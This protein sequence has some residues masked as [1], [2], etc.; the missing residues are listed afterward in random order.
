VL[1]GVGAEVGFEASQHD[2]HRAGHAEF[3]LDAA[4][5]RRLI[6]HVAIGAASAG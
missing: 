2:G 5:R 1:A 6:V 4:Q 3:L